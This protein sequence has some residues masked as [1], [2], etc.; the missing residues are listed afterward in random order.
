MRKVVR[1]QQ[2]GKVQTPRSKKMR[3]YRNAGDFASFKGPRY[4]RKEK[5]TVEY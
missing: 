2:A 1:R 5:Y 4:S 3:D